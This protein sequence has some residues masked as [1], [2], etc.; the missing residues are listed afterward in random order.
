[1]NDTTR[2]QKFISGFSYFIFIV[3]LVSVVFA[4]RAVTSIAIGVLFVFS[5][6]KNKI[7]TGSWFNKNL[8]HPFIVS[9]IL[10]FLLQAAGWLYAEDKS[11]ALHVL[12]IKTI[13]LFLPVGLA[14][15]NYTSPAFLNKILNAWSLVIL[16]AAAFC[17]G[18]AVYQYSIT[19][20]LYG[21]STSTGYNGS[22]FYCSVKILFCNNER[23]F[24]YIIIHAIQ[25]LPA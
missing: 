17:V 23:R 4:F 1:M 19:G 11:K 15:G 13:L 14:A 25:M 12:Q 3:L 9:T 22:N 18:F 10:F 7:E 5:F 24:I 20:D 16:V 6:A 21:F 2:T 8:L